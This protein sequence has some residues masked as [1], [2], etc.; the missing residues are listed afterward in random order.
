M[1]VCMY[2]CL[3]KVAQLRTIDSCNWCTPL[4]IAWNIWNTPE[5]SI[6]LTYAYRVFYL[7][8]L[9]TTKHCLPCISTYVNIYI[10]RYYWPDTG[11]G[12]VFGFIEHLGLVTTINFNIVVN[13]RTRHLTAEQANNQTFIVFTSPSMITESNRGDPLASLLMFSSTGDCLLTLPSCNCLRGNSHPQL[14]H[15]GDWLCLSISR[16]VLLLKTVAS[17]LFLASGLVEIFEQDSCWLLDMCVFERG[18]SLRKRKGG[19]SLCVGAV[20]VA[21]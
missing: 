13:L 1:Y 9:R 18:T 15:D 6:H 19:Q 12:L 2:V 16:P 4:S 11:V 17:N 21:L 7:M 14:T 10:V 5:N 3:C 8:H 20:F